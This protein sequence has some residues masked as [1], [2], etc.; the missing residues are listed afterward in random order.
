MFDKRVGAWGRAEAAARGA[1]QLAQ[2]QITNTSPGERGDPWAHP[3]AEET[4]AWTREPQ[5]GSSSH[6]HTNGSS[7][8]R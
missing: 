6:H 5:M 3:R 7:D 8:A 1:E 4:V 2:A